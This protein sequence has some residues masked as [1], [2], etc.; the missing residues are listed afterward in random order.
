M[1]LSERTSAGLP[2]SFG[3]PPELSADALGELMLLVEG[4][5]LLPEGFG[6]VKESL[7]GELEISHRG[8]LGLGNDGATVL[9]VSSRQGPLYFLF[10]QG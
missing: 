6:F 7:A 3:Q 2:T 1:P 10:N 4:D 8:V 5:K 9:V